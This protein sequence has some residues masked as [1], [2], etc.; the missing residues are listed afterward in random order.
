[1]RLSFPNSI[2]D[3]M[4]FRTS[5]FMKSFC[6]STCRPSQSESLT[7][8]IYIRQVLI[9]DVNDH[10]PVFQRSQY[11]ATVMENGGPS[12]FITQVVAKDT[13]ESDISKLKYSI[14][15]GF[16]TRYFRIDEK[17]GVV[18]LSEVSGITL[19]KVYAL[20]I[21][22]FDGNHT[23]YTKLDVV[24]GQSNNHPPKFQKDVYEAQVPENY[25]ADSYVA[26]VTA[27]DQDSGKF[28]EVTYAI[29]SPALTIDF[30]IDPKTGIITTKGSLDRELL[31]SV[32]IPVRASDA[33]GETTICNVKVLYTEEILYNTMN[34]IL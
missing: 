21:S 30:K 20:K 25:P 9:Q 19:G 2:P 27:T 1:M 32:T 28:G 3:S 31:S 5:C 24:V 8:Q 17:S 6:S 16:G 22:V 11:Q 13:D 23:A 26:M 29:D 10:A 14:V 34:T 7:L 12:H 33:G 15:P 4:S 18:S